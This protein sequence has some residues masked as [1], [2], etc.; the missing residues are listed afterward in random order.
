M[1]FK[2]KVT[3]S[4]EEQIEAAYVWF[5]ANNPAFA[6]Q[7]FRQLMDEIGKLQDKP[8]R[9]PRALERDIFDEEVRQFQYGKGRSRYRVLFS[10]LE[11]VVYVLYVRHSSQALLTLE[12][13]RPSDSP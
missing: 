11:E 6:D 4:A 5:R 3:R 1:A 10:I 9:F 7:W 8:R 13:L 12:D 2:V